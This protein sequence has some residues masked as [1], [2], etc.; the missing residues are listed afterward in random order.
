MLFLSALN[1]PTLTFHADSYSLIPS[2][3]DSRPGDHGTASTGA[4]AVAWL[5]RSWRFAM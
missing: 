1:L 2:S 4:N 3:P 5:A